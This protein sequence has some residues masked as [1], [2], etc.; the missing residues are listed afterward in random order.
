MQKFPV[1]LLTSSTNAIVSG[2]PII[3]DGNQVVVSTDENLNLHTLASLARSNAQRLGGIETQNSNISTVLN[4]ALPEIRQIRLS[5]P[6]LTQRL[7]T[8]EELLNG[9]SGIQLR[10]ATL[11]D[12][13][14][15]LEQDINNIISAGGG[16][17]TGGG[18]LS[19]T[20]SAILSALNNGSYIVG[21]GGIT[22]E[23]ISTGSAAGQYRIRLAGQ[24]VQTTLSSQTD[25]IDVQ[26]PEPGQYQIVLAQENLRNYITATR[27]LTVSAA[28][29]DMVVI[30]PTSDLIKGDN[31][32]IKVTFNEQTGTFTLSYIGTSG[33]GSGGGLTVDGTT[34]VSV[35]GVA[36]VA[37]TMLRATAGEL[38]YE[39]SNYNT[40]LSAATLARFTKY[41]TTEMFTQL[42]TVGLTSV[43]D[44]ISNA[45]L[46]AA[47]KA[48]VFNSANAPELDGSFYMLRDA[49]NVQATI[50][51]I[52]NGV[53]MDD[54]AALKNFFMDLR[55]KLRTENLV[56][57]PKKFASNFPLTNQ[58]LMF[59]FYISVLSHIG[60]GKVCM[61]VGDVLRYGRITG[62]GY[63]AELESA[64]HKFVSNALLASKFLTSGLYRMT[65]YFGIKVAN[66]ADTVFQSGFLGNFAVEP[67]VTALCQFN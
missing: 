46:S 29:T 30:Q 54:S 13:V 10:T 34:L 19:S 11:E 55:V 23:K 37:P 25:L 20:Y 47:L 57:P 65:T 35:A 66:S 53:L 36:Q 7:G 32:T 51:H 3:W 67:K 38:K 59:P 61:R 63:G 50:E 24:Q 56:Y 41:S 2:C 62:D 18:G 58:S 5:L 43:A 26:M 16:S 12:R 31:S 1:E 52:T 6:Q 49:N 22:V 15:S 21:D 48:F 39:S 33:G 8:I 17:G 64:E 28:N 45:D 42:T 44:V 9:T 60:T 14:N 27:G 40:L 4:E